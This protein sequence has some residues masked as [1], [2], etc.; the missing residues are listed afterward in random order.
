MRCKVSLASGLYRGF[1]ELVKWI[2]GALVLVT[3]F[4]LNRIIGVFCGAILGSIFGAS[5][6]TSARVRS[7]MITSIAH[8][9]VYRVVFE[10]YF[11]RLA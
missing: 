7:A 4:I 6:L 5:A 11:E 9:R 8:E 1:G 10:Q 3:W 2:V